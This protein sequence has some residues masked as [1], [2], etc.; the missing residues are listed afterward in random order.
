MFV[1]QYRFEHLQKLAQRDAEAWLEGQTAPIQL[2]GI[3]VLDQSEAGTA[4]KVQLG[5]SEPRSGEVLLVE[6]KTQWQTSVS[7]QQLLD[8]LDENSQPEIEQ[9][10][11]SL[12]TQRSVASWKLRAAEH[13]I[14]RKNYLAPVADQDAVA[15][16]GTSRDKF[17][18]AAGSAQ[19]KVGFASLSRQSPAESVSSSTS[20]GGS[21]QPVAV[22]VGGEAA[23]E[24]TSVAAQLEQELLLAKSELD[25]IQST[26]Q[27][28]LA[29][30][31]GALEVAQPT[32]LNPTSSPIPLWM[33]ASIIILGCC[34][35]ASAGWFQHRLQAGGIFDPARVASQMAD[36]GVPVLTS[37]HLDDRYAASGDWSDR[38]RRNASVARRFLAARIVRLSEYAL[39]FWVYMIA[40]RLVLDPMWR[41]VLLESPLAALGRVLVGMP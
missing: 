36:D 9:V 21:S 24:N 2:M 6:V 33:A 26:W 4:P 37:V 30:R 39:W 25:S 12:A 35:A 19:P 18:L 8:W 31:A 7:Q 17:T 32:D 23:E 1:S 41:S 16:A 38:L 5:D 40:F 20:E 3:K 13:Y 11:D 14:S 34:S 22:V 15:D 27:E 29:G 28:R 10:D